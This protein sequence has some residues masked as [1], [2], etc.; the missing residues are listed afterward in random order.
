MFAITN[1]IRDNS[2]S[3]LIGVIVSSIGTSAAVYIVVSITGYL[4]FGNDI[5]ANIISMCKNNDT[6]LRSSR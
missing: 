6:C 3:S 5:V 2:P 4:T 1:E